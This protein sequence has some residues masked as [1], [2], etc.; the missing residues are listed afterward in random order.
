MRFV[1]VPIVLALAAASTPA[2][3]NQKMAAV[4]EIVVTPPQGKA[5]HLALSRDGNHVAYRLVGVA[6]KGIWLF[7]RKSGQHRQ[8]AEDSPELAHYAPAFSPDG[9]SVAYLAG[10]PVVP[11]SFTKVKVLTLAD[12]SRQEFS[13]AAFSWSPTSKRIAIAD[14]ETGTLKIGTVKS[15][16][17]VET[18]ELVP[19]WDPLEPP[20][21]AWS[22]DGETIAYTVSLPDQKIYGIRTTNA[23]RKDV[24][25]VVDYEVKRAAIYPF[26][27]PDGRLAWHLIVPGDDSY[28]EIMALDASGK[29]ESLYRN[30][31]VDAAGRPAWSPDGKTIAFLRTPRYHP[32]TSYGPTDVW[33]LDVLTKSTRAITEVGDAAGDLSWS[34]DGA[35]IFLQAGNRLRIIRP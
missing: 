18:A 32:H 13:G 16:R 7:D 30:S 31:L 8:L 29:P 20:A 28:S 19:G 1:V 5:T 15:G 22:P 11:P 21:M 25:K 34:E 26:W 2:E 4:E 23:Q 3:E 10:E 33:L 35:S 14:R 27:S 24:V 9:K 17:V 6:T 12:N